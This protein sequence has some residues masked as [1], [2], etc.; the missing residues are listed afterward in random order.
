MS[1]L[2]KCL[3]AFSFTVCALL[4]AYVS[5]MIELPALI[6]DGAVLQRDHPIPI[7]GKA[8]ANTAVSVTLGNRTQSTNSNSEGNWSVGFSALPAGGP[9]TLTISAGQQ[10]RQ[11]QNLYMGDVWVASGQSNMEWLLR[12]AQGAEAEMAAPDMPQ[13]RHYKVPLSWSATTET[14][15]AGG[16]W[17]AATKS[18]KGDFSA[19]AYFFAKSI[20]SE[21]QSDI[22][23]PIGL[24]GSNWGGSRIEA[25]MSPEALGKSPQ[26]TQQAIAQLGAES[27]RETRALRQTLQRW[28][29]ALVESMGSELWARARSDWSATEL[30]TEDWLALEAPTLWEAQ[31]FPGMDGVV[32]YRKA[33]MLSEAEAAE[34]L[35]LSLGRIDDKDITWV[36][37]HKVGNTDTY[38]RQRQYTVPKNCLNAGINIIAIRV[39]DTGGGGG[40]YSSPDLLYLET[41]AGRHSLAGSWKI[42]PDKVALSPIGNMNHVDTALYNKMLHPLYKVP[43]KGV[44]WYQGESN[45]DT[46]EE[47]SHYA[48]QFQALIK[49]WRKGWQQPEMPFYWVQLANFNS[50]RNT[51]AGKPWAILRESQSAALA[52]PN[53][54]QAITIDVGDADDIHPRDKKTVGDRLALIALKQTYG[55]KDVHYRGPVFSGVEV[56]KN[57]LILRFDS[58]KPLALTGDQEAVHGFEIIRGN[59]TTKAVQGKLKGRSVVIETENPGEVTLIRYAWDDNPENANLVDTTGLP[60]EPFRSEVK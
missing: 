22:S 26:Q 3:T 6:S 37:G 25:W 60:A 59:G 24:I 18:L 55:Q 13:V 47:A 21:I 28:P 45:A 50:G 38:D 40:I 41:V 4:P 11:V 30:D 20:H 14:D 48:H 5:A 10:S 43:V 27:I 19:V 35:A 2:F 32:W 57:R 7:W 49:D 15:L 16:Q 9:L 31:G 36:N 56:K 17:Q 23:V 42:K 33:F 54:G 34:P 12:D 8:P 58:T 51:E 39:E 52:L 46:V 44:L 53:T 29:G 1:K